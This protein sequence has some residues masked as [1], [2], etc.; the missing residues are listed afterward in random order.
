MRIVRQSATALMIVT[1]RA[2]AQSL[3]LR[4]DHVSVHPRARLGR[5]SRVFVAP[6]GRL[7]LGPGYVG[8]NVTIQVGEGGSMILNGHFIG[9]SSVLVGRSSITVEEG[10]M[11]AEMCVVR[12]SDHVRQ[13]DGSLTSDDHISAPV[14]IARHSWLASRSTVLKGVTVGVAA[15]V[16]AGAVVT[17]DVAAGALVG[18]VPARPLSVPGP[19]P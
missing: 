19:P 1:E 8:S 2:R 4:F 6:G 10:V 11:I 16:A 5:G 18:G 7:V 13:S 14:H 3:R 17:K 9:P 15:T 12:D